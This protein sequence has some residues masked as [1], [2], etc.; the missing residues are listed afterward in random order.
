MYYGRKNSNA[1][2]SACRRSATAANATP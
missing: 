1:L 2:G